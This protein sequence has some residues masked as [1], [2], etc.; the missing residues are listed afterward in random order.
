MDKNITFTEKRN[1]FTEKRNSNLLRFN[2]MPKL[3]NYLNLNSH[4]FKIIL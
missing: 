3:N 2:Y 1:K 4:S